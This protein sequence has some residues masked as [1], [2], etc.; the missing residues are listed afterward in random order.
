MIELREIRQ[1]EKHVLTA[2]LE[3]YIFELSAYD[4]S[5][6]N[7]SGMYG[8]PEV[9]LYWQE[10]TRYAYWITTEGKTIGLAMVFP[11]SEL[12]EPC[13]WSMAEFCIFPKYRRYGYG[14]EAAHAVMRRHK[15][16]WQIVKHP[17]NDRADA[18]WRKAVDTFT[19]GKYRFLK[20]G[21]KE[22]YHD[23][24]HGDVICFRS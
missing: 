6:M 23:G 22:P 10:E 13:D 7:E 8:C 14:C 17:A 4:L 18:F 3:K 9:D 15:G 12:D 24:S 2:I 11:Y 5:D 1:E 21:A 16:D 20:N 19:N